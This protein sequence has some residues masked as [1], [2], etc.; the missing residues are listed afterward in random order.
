MCGIAGIYHYQGDR[1]VDPDRLASMTDILAHRGPDDSG[2][3]VSGP[4]GL[5]HRRLSIVDLSPAGRN[6]MPNEDETLW[7][8]L[9]GEIYN[10]IDRRA[11]FEARGHRFRSHTDTEML[12]HLYEEKGTAFVDDLRGM[13]GIALWDAPHRTLVVVRDRLG[14]KPIYWRDA[15]GTFAYASEMKAL[16]TTRTARARS[17]PHAVQDYLALQY[18]PSP[19]SMIQGIHKLP[20]GHM[21]IVSPQGVTVRRY[22]AP[23]TSGDQRAL[24]R[25]RRGRAPAPARG[26]GAACAS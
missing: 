11:E 7:V 15:H 16:L 24:V 3:Y 17:I 8:T 14:I 2:L 10:V 4:I 21:L 23:P 1:R 22:W 18:V 26:I 25:R 12:L 20:P 5:G 13:F 6:P 9:N 19:R